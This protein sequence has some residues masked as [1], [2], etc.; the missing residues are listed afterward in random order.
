MAN[1]I[2]HREVHSETPMCC[3]AHWT[4]LSLARDGQAIPRSSYTQGWKKC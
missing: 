2:S 3:N 1:M 4:E